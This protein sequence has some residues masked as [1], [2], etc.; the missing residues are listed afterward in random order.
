MARK[1]GVCDNEIMVEPR[2][3]TNSSFRLDR[4]WTTLSTIPI[5]N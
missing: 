1:S 3:I 2:E 5:V 4:A